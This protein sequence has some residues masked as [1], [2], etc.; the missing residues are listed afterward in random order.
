MADC[1]G[2][3][4]W[5]NFSPDTEGVEDILEYLRKKRDGKLK[6]WWNINP[7]VGFMTVSRINGTCSP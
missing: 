1:C 2:L 4:Q 5:S 6:K 3:D 7:R